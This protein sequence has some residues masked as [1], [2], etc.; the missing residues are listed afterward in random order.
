MQ[1]LIKPSIRQTYVVFYM[2]KI[3]ERKKLIKSL[4]RSLGWWTG[5]QIRNPFQPFCTWRFASSLTW[6]TVMPRQ[7]RNQFKETF[8]RKRHI[9]CQQIRK[10][11]DFENRTATGTFE[12]G[13]VCTMVQVLLAS[14]FYSFQNVPASCQH[15]LKSAGSRVRP[16]DN[17]VVLKLV[18][19]VNPP[20]LLNWYLVGQCITAHR[21]DLNVYD[22]TDHKFCIP[23]YIEI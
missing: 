21:E 19:G 12:N 14:H 6:H 3:Q 13:I 22:T 10:M 5:L 11:V 20:Q 7:L 1:S 8:T 17:V 15:S 18:D 4:L 23:K 9:F 16:R 2:N